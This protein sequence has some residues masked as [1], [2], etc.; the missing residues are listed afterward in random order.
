M[1]TELT[2]M[3]LHDT[4]C[5]DYEHIVNIYISHLHDTL[6][7]D[8]EPRVNIHDTRCQDYYDHRVK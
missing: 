7:Q 5:Q 6:C 8:Y 1:S 4:M 3:H 2:H